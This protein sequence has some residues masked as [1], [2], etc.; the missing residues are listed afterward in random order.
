M[1]TCTIPK[2][3]RAGCGIC[4]K[5]SGRPK[6]WKQQPGLDP[7]GHH[8]GLT[9]V[10]DCHQPPTLPATPMFG[11]MSTVALGL[12][13]HP[14][15]SFLAEGVPEKPQPAAGLA[16]AHLL[17]SVPM[18]DPQQTVGYAGRSWSCCS[19]SATWLLATST[20]ALPVCTARLA[21][22]PARGLTHTHRL[23]PSWVDLKESPHLRPRSVAPPAQ[24]TSSC[25]Q[26]QGPSCEN[27]LAGKCSS[28]VAPEMG[29]KE[30]LLEE[31]R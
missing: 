20:S 26:P 11:E 17:L 13:S 3:G 16:S 22:A 19:L 14:G 27:L 31:R 23:L 25:W 1:G 21:W 30:R 15:I 2:E 10:G 7:T 29:Q 28:E 24:P 9:R 8:Q 5:P 6:V 18:A 4:W 12:W